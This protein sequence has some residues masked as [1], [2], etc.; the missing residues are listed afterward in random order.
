MR[1]TGRPEVSF[2]G[3]GGTETRVDYYCRHRPNN[4]NK[5]RTQGVAG[6][7]S[8]VEGRRDTMGTPTEEK[9]QVWRLGETSGVYVSLTQ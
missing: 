8:R 3:T 5:I 6:G 9:L 2:T 1:E 4:L 7:P